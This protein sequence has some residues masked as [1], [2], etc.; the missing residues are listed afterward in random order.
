MVGGVKRT[1]AIMLLVVLMFAAGCSEEV[2]TGAGS[3][4]PTASSG[5]TPAASASLATVPETTA[6]TGTLEGGIG[7]EPEVVLRVEGDAGV[8]FSGLCSVGDEDTVLGGESVPVPKRYAF[9]PRGERLSCKIQ[10]QDPGEGDLK[11]TLLAGDSTRSVQQTST[12]EG[13]INVT[14]DGG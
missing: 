1:T 10:K 4:S 14:Y 7:E 6:Q 13:A 8:T 5:P 2:S 11:V 3:G 9:D 12:P